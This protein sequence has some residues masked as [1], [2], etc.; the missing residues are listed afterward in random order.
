MA[1]PRKA[2]PPRWDRSKVLDEAEALRKRIKV[3][4]LVNIAKLLRDGRL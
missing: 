4:R 3:K 2:K 1:K